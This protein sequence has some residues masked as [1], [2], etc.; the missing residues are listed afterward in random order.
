MA[1]DYFLGIAWFFKPKKPIAKADQTA[2]KDNFISQYFGETK[3]TF[4]RDCKKLSKNGM[5][6]LQDLKLLKWKD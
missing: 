3:L 6:R 1:I 4:I 2:K 5:K